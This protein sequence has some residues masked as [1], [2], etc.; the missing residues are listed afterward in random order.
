MGISK[1]FF[2]FFETLEIQIV[3][4]SSKHVFY[5][6]QYLTSILKELR[7]C[8]LCIIPVWSL[9]CSIRVYKSLHFLQIL[10]VKLGFV[11]LCF[12]FS[13]FCISVF[14]FLYICSFAISFEFNVLI[15]LITWYNQS[16]TK[17]NHVLFKFVF[18]L[19]RSSH[20]KC[21]IQKAVLNPL[22]PGGNKKVTHTLANLQLKPAGLFKYG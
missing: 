1:Y 17:T 18:T 10:L 6:V 19:F 9:F 7:N 13:C 8:I 14:L 15:D 11:F 5:S 21:F 3:Y 20:R 16:G 12:G 2:F 4:T 22:M